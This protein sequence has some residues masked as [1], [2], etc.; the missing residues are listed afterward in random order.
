MRRLACDATTAAS[1]G[2]ATHEREKA[3]VVAD[4]DLPPLS[5]ELK[6]RASCRERRRLSFE[7]TRYVS[8][9]NVVAGRFFF[10]FTLS[11]VFFEGR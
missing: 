1:F 6:E 7:C 10:V 11:G 5:A 3:K 4:E 8:T 2:T 9:T